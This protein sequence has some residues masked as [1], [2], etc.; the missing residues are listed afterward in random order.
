MSSNNGSVR[1]PQMLL[2]LLNNFMLSKQHQLQRNGK[3]NEK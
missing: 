1:D 3:K 2:L